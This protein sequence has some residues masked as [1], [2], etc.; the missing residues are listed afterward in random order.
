MRVKITTTTPGLFFR[1][2]EGARSKY[3]NAIEQQAAL[4]RHFGQSLTNRLPNNWLTHTPHPELADF[5]MIRYDTIHKEHYGRECDLMFQV[6][7]IPGMTLESVIGDVERVMSEIKDIPNL[8]YKLTI[9][10]NG[11]D[12]PYHME[13]M[14]IAHDNPLVVALAEGQTLASGKSAQLG[15]WR[16]DCR[17]D[18][19]THRISF[20]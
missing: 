5:P 16:K 6:R 11:S 17:R 9:P 1:F 15:S 7:T 14:E 8:E 2:T 4:I 3:T 19:D 20:S 18:Q 12:D 13:P 10:A